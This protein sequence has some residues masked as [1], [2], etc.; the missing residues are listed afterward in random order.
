MKFDGNGYVSY[1]VL[2]QFRQR[3]SRDTDVAL[4]YSDKFE[5]RL[6]TQAASRRMIIWTIKTET[7]LN[8]LE[9]IFRSVL[10]C[11]LVVHVLL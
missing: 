8:R 4:K 5:I 11:G 6:R 7:Q 2:N 1:E 10:Q 9:V 3:A